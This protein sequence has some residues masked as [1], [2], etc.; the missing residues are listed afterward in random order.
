V[1]SFPESHFFRSLHQSKSVH[2][3]RTFQKYLEDSGIRFSPSRFWPKPVKIT[4][5]RRTLDRFAKS[6]GYAAWVEKT[7]ANLHYIPL[8]Q[9]YFDD[10]RFVHVIRKP[11]DTVASLYLVTKQYPELW[12]GTRSIRECIDR[13][14]K[15]IL[16]SKQ[17]VGNP[18]HFFLDYASM[19]EN[20]LEIANRV[21]SWWGLA[22]M[23]SL[24][25]QSRSLGRIIADNEHWKERNF[26]R[27]ETAQSKFW[28]LA[29]SEREAI[30]EHADYA[31]YQAITEQFGARFNE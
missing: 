19:T 10:V 25:G 16:I 8:I 22:A 3:F 30:R 31:S 1:L 21:I 4:V 2:G 26:G 24:G 7:P 12:G 6:H 13:W 28:D 27:I 5:F 14:N 15:D 17:Y 29:E 9:K 23:D 18:T 20:P 11:Q